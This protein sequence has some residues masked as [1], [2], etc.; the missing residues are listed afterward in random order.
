MAL[1]PSL[2]QQIIMTEF[3]GVIKGGKETFS[4]TV[5]VAWA[6]WKA[7]HEGGRFVIFED[8]DERSLGQLRLYRAWLDRMCDQ[9]GNDPDDMHEYLIDKCAP[10]VVTTIKGRKKTIEVERKK[11]TSG[12]HK[13]SMDKLEMQTFMERCAAL[14]QFPLPTPE[15]LEALGYLVR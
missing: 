5:A 12:G 7:R 14:T 4:P 11:R 10:T 8:K 2:R 15:E 3:H 13:F 6:K 1:L 9:T